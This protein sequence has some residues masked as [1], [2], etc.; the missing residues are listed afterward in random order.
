MNECVKSIC[1][2][3]I[4]LEFKIERIKDGGL[5]NEKDYFTQEK[6]YSDK[7]LKPTDHNGKT[8]FATKNIKDA[9]K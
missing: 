4:L 8:S 9:H 7:E 2:N 6:Y 3:V 5:L 1:T